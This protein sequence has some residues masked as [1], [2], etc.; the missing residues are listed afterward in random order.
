ML[1]R[2][3]LAVTLCVPFLV[4]AKIDL[5]TLPMRDQVQLT[6]YNPADLTLVTEQRSLTLK[7]GINHLEFSWENTLIDPT[8]VQLSAPQHADQVRLLEVAYPPNTQNSAI[9]RIESQVGGEIPVEISFFTSGISW[10]SHYLALLSSDEQFLHLQHFVRVDNRSGEDYENAQTRL[11]LGQ[12]QLIDEIA[13]LARRSPPYGKPI[14]EMPRQERISRAMAPAP[15]A[16]SFEMDDELEASAGAFLD[17]KQVFKEQ[18]S[19]YVIYTIEGTETILNQWGKRLQAFEKEKIPVEALYR[20]DEQRYG[21]E[22]RRFLSF[23]NNA[24]HQLG[25]NPLPEGTVNLFRKNAD[26]H[27]TFIADTT[28]RYIPVEQNIEW[29]LGVA[30]EV[31]IEP[32]LLHYATENYLF[33]NRG[34]VDGFDRVEKWQ[35]TVRNM[36]SLPIVVEIMRHAPHAYWQVQYTEMAHAIYE[37]LDSTRFQ[38][39]LRLNPHS[40]AVLN[41]TLT[42]R[43]GSR[44]SDR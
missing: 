32:V 40:E 9:W 19:E 41:Y 16:E 43:E 6:I 30:R 15:Q 4:Y 25:L 18:L 35:L 44:Q 37:R 28:M 3:F 10:Q 42:L 21:T 27:L 31:L 39:R 7:P 8:S 38:Y 5:V 29:D 13:T 20:H 23:V 1:K 17:L 26:S 11:L 24:E 2:I 34:N 12:V 36:Q 33:D 22:T 14:I